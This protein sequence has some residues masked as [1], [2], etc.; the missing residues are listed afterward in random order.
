MSEVGPACRSAA[1]LAG[2]QLIQCDEQ[3]PASP[4]L[5]FLS[6]DS[7]A[8]TVALNKVTAMDATRAMAKLDIPGPFRGKVRIWEAQA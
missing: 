3:A 2:D 4:L 6:T 7:G 5:S 1:V 8:L